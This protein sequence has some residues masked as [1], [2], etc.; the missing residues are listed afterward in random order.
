[1]T[2]DD[3]LDHYAKEFRKLP[4][5]RLLQPEEVAHAIVYLASDAASGVTGAEWYVDVGVRRSH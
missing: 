3:A 4:L 2:I 5:G 1:M